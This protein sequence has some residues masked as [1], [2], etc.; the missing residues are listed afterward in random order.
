MTGKTKLSRSVVPL[1]RIAIVFILLSLLSAM[2]I[3]SG[4]V[5]A[6]H[7]SIGAEDTDQ[8]SMHIE[9]IAEWENR[10]QLGGYFRLFRVN[11]Y[12]LYLWTPIEPSFRECWLDENG[13]IRNV[14][15]L[16]HRAF[17]SFN[18]T[19]SPSDPSS[20]L[21]R[22]VYM[23]YNMND[24]SLVIFSDLN[25][26]R[27]QEVF[28]EMKPYKNANSSG[29]PTYEEISKHRV[30]PAIEVSRKTIVNTT[31]INSP[32]NPWRLIDKLLTKLKINENPDTTI[33]FV[34]WL[35]LHPREY[36]N[37][38]LN[39]T[40]DYL[41]EI[42]FEAYFNVSEYPDVSSDEE[43]FLNITYYY[44][45]ADLDGNI[46]YL[47]RN[48]YFYN[49]SAIVDI[50]YSAESRYRSRTNPLTAFIYRF[51]LS[52]LSAGV[53]IALVP[54]VF[55]ASVSYTHLTLPTKA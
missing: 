39:M 55:M 23:R 19:Y 33:M 41:W 11:N 1:K 8:A 32:L 21:N 20:L 9:Y 36:L 26:T 15:S 27:F 6:P 28:V 51:W 50:A 53:G 35:F 3:F 46:V 7:P 14:T 22:D 25:N 40:H 43:I 29:F 44:L 34:T 4:P 12:F 10:S 16:W 30:S 38:P 37:P 5:L 48:S 17:Y 13:N 49:S 2:L 24:T 52:L 31:D 45:F 42:Q 18:S 54:L 47:G